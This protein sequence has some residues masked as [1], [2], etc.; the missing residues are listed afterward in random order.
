M[1]VSRAVGWAA[2]GQR[3]DQVEQLERSRGSRRTPTARTSIPALERRHVPEYVPGARAVD[4]CG[5]VSVLSICCR[6][7]MYRTM[8]KPNYF[9]TTTR[10]AYSPR[11]FG[12]STCGGVAPNTIQI[13]SR[14]V[15]AVVD[16]ARD[17]AGG[18][19]GCTAGRREA[20]KQLGA[21]IRSAS[22]RR[23]PAPAQLQQQRHADDQQ[24][25]EEAG[26]EGGLEGRGKSRRPT[27]SGGACRSRSSGRR[28]TRRRRPSAARPAA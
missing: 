21:A 16:E 23:A 1:I 19:P 15:V 26:V 2:A 3:H 5:L 22:T 13:A 10:M 12:A 20:G 27:D 9:Q 7:A 14:A 11:P 6:P 17:Q 8:R 24:L 28:C 25:V 4:A 18:I